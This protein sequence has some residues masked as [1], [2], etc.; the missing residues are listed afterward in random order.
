M[1]DAKSL[2]LGEGAERSEADEG[3]RFCFLSVV[4]DICEM[5]LPR[6]Y[7]ET[8]QKRRREAPF[9]RC[10]YMCIVLVLITGGKGYAVVLPDLSGRTRAAETV[11]VLHSLFGFSLPTSRLHV[12][13]GHIRTVWR[14]PYAGR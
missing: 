12:P 7:R 5:H 9:L 1:L 6:K 2:L 11:R 8:R 13:T 4:D 3:K 10:V 14:R